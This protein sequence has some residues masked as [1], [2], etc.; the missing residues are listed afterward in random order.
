[1]IRTLMLL[2]AAATRHRPHL[3]EAAGAGAIVV[4]LVQWQGGWAG[5]I[6]GGT[7]LVLK[8]WES[9]IAALATARD[10][11]GSDR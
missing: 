5:W 11:A 6:A 8:A 4:G 7:A 3:V 10:K 9:D 1:M 2:V